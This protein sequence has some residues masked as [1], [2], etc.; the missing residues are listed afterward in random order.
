MA[1]LEKKFLHGKPSSLEWR[2]LS[3]AMNKKPA[4]FFDPSAYA[5]GYRKVVEFYQDLYGAGTHILPAAVHSHQVVDSMVEEAG[6]YKQ[7][8]ESLP[9]GKALGPDSMAP[10]FFS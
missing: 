2:A 4:N 5:E 10:E 7:L 9:K 1:K 8:V 3:K 6:G